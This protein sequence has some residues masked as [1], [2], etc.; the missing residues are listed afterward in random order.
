MRG[1]GRHPRMKILHFKPFGVLLYSVVADIV[2]CNRPIILAGTEITHHCV[3]SVHNHLLARDCA[4][5]VLHDFHAVERIGAACH[6]T[7]SIVVAKQI[8]ID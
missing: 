6:G 3:A 1:H 2:P 4:I 8:P 5:L 7:L